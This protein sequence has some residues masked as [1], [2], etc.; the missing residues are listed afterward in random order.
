MPSTL[1][2]ARLGRPARATRSARGREAARRPRGGGDR[3]RVAAEAAEAASRRTGRRRRAAAAARPR[4]GGTTAGGGGTTGVVVDRLPAPRCCRRGS[5]SRCRRSPRRRRC[6]SRRGT[7]R[8]AAAAGGSAGVLSV[9]SAVAVRER[10]MLITA[11]AR[12]AAGARPADERRALGLVCDEIDRRGL[13]GPQATAVV[14]V[15]QDAVDADLALAAA[16]DRR[17]AS[18]T[19]TVCTVGVV[20]TGSSVVAVAHDRAAPLPP[21]RTIAT[22]AP[23]KPSASRNAASSGSVLLPPPN[24]DPERP[25]RADGRGSRELGHAASVADRPASGN[26][27]RAPGPAVDRAAAI[28]APGCERSRCPSTAVRRCWSSS[29][30]RSPSPGRARS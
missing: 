6:R 19:R 15:A 27:G 20:F 22:T 10:S 25:S 2:V 7:R 17:S 4:G 23:R 8:L 12:A 11:A 28:L 30:C 29:T 1:V 24:A 21:P 13:V 9:N 16:R 26:S 3:R 14:A 18:E 5:R